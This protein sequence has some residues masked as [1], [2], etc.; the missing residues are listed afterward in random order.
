MTGNRALEGLRSPCEGLQLAGVGKQRFRATC[1]SEAAQPNRKS[2]MVLVEMAQTKQAPGPCGFE[3]LNRKVPGSL[4]LSLRLECS[5]T[6]LVHCTCASRVQMIL[7]PQPPEA[8]D[9]GVACSAY[10]PYHHCSGNDGDGVLLCRQAGVQ[11]RNLGSLQPPPPGF[12]RFSRLSLLSSWDHRHSLTPSLGARLECHGATSAHHNLRLLGSS[13]SPAIASRVAGTTG[14][15]HHAWLIFC[16]FSRDGVSPCWPGW[17]RSLDLMIRP[18][19]PPKVPSCVPIPSYLSTGVKPVLG[20]DLI[21]KAVGKEK[22]D[23][24]LNLALLR[25]LK[26]SGTISAQF[27]LHLLG[28]KMGSYHDGQADLELLTSVELPTLVSQSAGIA[29][30]SHHAQPSRT[31]EDNGA[32]SAHHNLCPLPQLWVEGTCFSLPI[33]MGFHHVG[34]AG[35]E[36]QTSGDPPASASQSPGITV[37]SRCAWL[38]RA[39]CFVTQAGGQCCKHDSLQPQPPGLKRSFCLR[40]Q[41]AG[42]SGT[43]HHTRL[44]LVFFVKK[45]FRHVGQAG[46]EFLSSATHP[47]QPPKVLGLQA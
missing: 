41:V 25:R 5:G 35:L 17:S 15:C 30:M 34:Q 22:Y 36:L 32:I 42:I 38:E 33:E 31:L 40:P 29:G 9:L 11:W 28:S 10:F 47:P 16:I 12:K 21:V 37:V 4:A 2:R 44:V 24:I 26:C 19:R 3:W 14:V 45:R 8:K 43:R 46:L 23:V 39:S 20:N 13:N 6:I 18:P 1:S 27:C 7:L